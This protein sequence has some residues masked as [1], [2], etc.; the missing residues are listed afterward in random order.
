MGGYFDLNKGDNKMTELEMVLNGIE[1][2][3][4]CDHDVF[5]WSAVQGFVQT[6]QDSIQS[7]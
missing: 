5:W 2:V 4:K 1:E 7:P 3:E 6:L